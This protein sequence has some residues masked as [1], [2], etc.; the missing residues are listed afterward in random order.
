MQT[1]TIDLGGCKP[2][3]YPFAADGTFITGAWAAS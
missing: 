3:P 2:N 1:Q